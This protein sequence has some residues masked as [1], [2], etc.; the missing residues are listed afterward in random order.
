MGYFNQA[1]IENYITADEIKVIVKEG[2]NEKNK[3]ELRLEIP[4]PLHDLWNRQS[5]FVYDVIHTKRGDMYFAED[6][7]TGRVRYFFYN[8]PGHGFGGSTY[9]LPMVDGS[10]ATLIGPWSSNSH[11]MNTV[12]HKPSKE[13]NIDSKYNMADAMT[14]DAI[15]ILLAPLDMECI[16][17]DN[18]PRIIRL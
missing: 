2:L 9:R 10:T 12:G 18:D 14:L 11:A 15:N 16:L 7:M 4:K 3:W 17:I 6:P 13:V 5:S 1:I 8:Q